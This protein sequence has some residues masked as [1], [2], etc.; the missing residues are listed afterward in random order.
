[1][2]NFYIFIIEIP[3]FYCMKKLLLLLFLSLYTYNCSLSQE[4]FPV[5][6]KWTYAYFNSIG[7]YY[8]QFPVEYMVEKDTIV[9]GKAC[10]KITPNGTFRYYNS[11]MVY[12]LE[13]AQDTIWNLL[14]DFTKSV[15][16]TI[17]YPQFTSV[18]IWTGDTI[19]YFNVVD[20]VFQ[21]ILNN[22]TLKGYSC[23]Y[24]SFL[25][26]SGPFGFKPFAIE[27]VYG[28]DL[29]NEGDYFDFGPVGLRCYEDSF[30]GLYKV[31]GF[32]L[33]C[34][35][36]WTSGGVGIIENIENNVEIFPNPASYNLN[37]QFKNI[38]LNYIT[39]KIFDL[40]GNLHKQSRI[41][42]ASQKLDV[43]DLESGM[44]I[45]EI[46]SEGQFHRDK[47]LIE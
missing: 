41:N 11:G 6:A 36:S 22:D 13:P 8:S 5:G 32:T 34:D 3:W 24:D 26:G 28:G 23:T 14:F 25:S 17:F 9:L 40:Q 37:I 47:L 1:M 39:F 44:Y 7:P 35:T 43:S 30:L 31:P 20:T 12:Y 33:D 4:W 19:T 46:E 27:R 42:Q 18:N 45:F 16:D 2:D 15:G 38:S 21:V 10:K 29:Y